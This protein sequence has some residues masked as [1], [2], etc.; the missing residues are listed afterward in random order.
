[1]SQAGAPVT[2]GDCQHRECV[3][4]ADVRLEFRNGER[5]VYCEHHAR[6]ITPVLPVEVVE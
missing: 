2:L 1:M 3:D 6:H 4:Q 5:R